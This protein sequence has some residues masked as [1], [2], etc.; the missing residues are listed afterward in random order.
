MFAYFTSRF[1]KINLICKLC[2]RQ[3]GI[4]SPLLLASSFAAKLLQIPN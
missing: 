1:V 4:F 3:G 2:E